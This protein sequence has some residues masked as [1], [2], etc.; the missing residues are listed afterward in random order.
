VQE[1]K[2]NKSRET[3]YRVAGPKGGYVYSEWSLL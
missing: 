1:N 3:S 2:I